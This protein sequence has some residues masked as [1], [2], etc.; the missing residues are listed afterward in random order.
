MMFKK[1]AHYNQSLKPILNWRGNCKNGRLSLRR[2]GL[3]TEADEKKKKKKWSPFDKENNM[4]KKILV[5]LI[6]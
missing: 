1:K 6:R 5:Y 4:S 3:M 2:E